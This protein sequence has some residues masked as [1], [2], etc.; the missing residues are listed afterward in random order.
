MHNCVCDD[1]GARLV[2]C[3]YPKLCVFRQFQFFVSG[4][5]ALI[6]VADA[7]SAGLVRL[8]HYARLEGEI[9]TSIFG[10]AGWWLAPRKSLHKS[11]QIHIERMIIIFFTQKA[12]G[13]D[14]RYRIRLLSFRTFAHD[15]RWYQTPIGS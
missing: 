6:V 10:I 3:Q 14:L 9:Y 15:K 1:A 12:M 2:S 8:Q 7:R 5:A 4:V 13:A 11:L